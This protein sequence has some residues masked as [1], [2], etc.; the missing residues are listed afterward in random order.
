MRKSSKLLTRQATLAPSSFNPDKRS[1]SV[2]WSTGAPVQRY[3]FEGGFVERL[4]LAPEAVDLSELRG[5]PLLN[6][7]NR[8]SVNEILGVVQDASVD[9]T[10]GLAT[11]RFS[12]RPEAQAVMRDV[13]DGIVSRVSVGYSVSKW[14]TEKDAS[15]NRTKTAIRWRPAEISFTAVAAD[16]GARTRADG[17]DEEE[18]DCLGE[19][20]CECD[21]EESEETMSA[22]PDQIRSAAALLGINENFAEQIATRDGITVEAARAEMLTHLRDSS[23]RIDARAVV[24]RDEGDTF[25]DRML[26]AVAYRVNPR[27]KLRDDA[28]PWVTR[29]LADVGREFLRVAGVSTLGNDDQI[30]QRWGAMH[31]TSDYGNFLA[32]LFNKQ[33]LPAYLIV[34]SG[35]KLLARAATVNDF[36]QKH[37]Y[38][39]SPMG[40]L[41]KVNEHGEFKRV[42]KSDVKPES[43][44]IASYAGVFAITRAAQINDDISVFADIGA[45]LSI[46]AAEFENAQ[47]AALLVSNPVMADGFA[48][49]STQ[50]N[51]LAGTGGAVG[52]T[53][54]SA[55]RLAMRLQSNQNGQPI[56]IRPM[57]L[58]APA[59]QET[60][61]QKALAAIYP[62]Q[63]QDANVFTDFVRLVVD[64]RLDKLGQ[65]LPWYLFGDVAT[66]P[67]L[68]F[69]YLSGYEGPRVSTRVGFAGG[70]DIDGTEVLCQLD[71]GCGVIGSQGA[72]KNPGA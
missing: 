38:R 9:G 72:Y 51:N 71:Y 12:E 29:R 61:A 15:G 23:P 58:L 46:Q 5:G 49:F 31:T 36:R 55:A 14:A 54:L 37:V 33:L 66:A 52:D 10:Q 24:V 44:A 60:T 63:T 13:A 53:T 19:D 22:V 7:H 40:P 41:Q 32:E 50:H 30:F 8:R 21:P 45:Q 3:D 35:L 56:D 42:D 59:T 65:T 47:L 28:R 39:N 70:S 57:Y 68:E 4:S 1:V 18:C 26:N 67:C 62:P 16:P 48:L 34:P 2:I 43:Y 69:S 64:P 6:S 20:G 27:I 17:A 25:M 11:V